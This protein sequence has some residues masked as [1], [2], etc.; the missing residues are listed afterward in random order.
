MRLSLVSPAV[1]VALA[2]GCA[3][4]PGPEYAVYDPVAVSYTH[5]RAHET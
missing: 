3:L 2:S 4:S 1:L 5:L